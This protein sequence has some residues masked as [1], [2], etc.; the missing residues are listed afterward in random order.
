MS[1]RRREG[2]LSRTHWVRSHLQV[3]DVLLNALFPA[4]LCGGLDYARQPIL[5]L[6]DCCVRRRWSD[7]VDQLADLFEEFV[8]IMERTEVVIRSRNDFHPY[9]GQRA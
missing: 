1:L 3:L 5:S 8:L 4:V 9:S 2:P 6:M 7:R